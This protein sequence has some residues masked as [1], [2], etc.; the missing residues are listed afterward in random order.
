VFCRSLDR[1][2]ELAEVM[3]TVR[4]LSVDPALAQ[5]WPRGGPGISGRTPGGDFPLVLFTGVMPSFGSIL[6]S[7][8]PSS[9]PNAALVPSAGWCRL[10]A[11]VRISV[12]FLVLLCL[13][14]AG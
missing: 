7:L 1:F 5:C 3:E 4:H 9:V 10:A 12:P 6:P 14:S 11:Q 2:V 8:S 13:P